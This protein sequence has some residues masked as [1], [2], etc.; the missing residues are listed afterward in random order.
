MSISSALQTGV[1]GL[2]ANSRA[3]GNISENIANANTVGYKRG[4]AQMVTTTSSGSSGSGVL[5]VSAVGQLDMETAGGLISTTSATDLAIGGNGFFVVSLN[6]NETAQSNYMLTRAGS[7][8]PD[9]NGDLKN[10]AGF[11]LAGYRY[12]LDGD[13]GSVD[14]STFAQMETVNLG[15]ISVSADGTSEMSTFGNLP[16]QDTG[17][18][19]P[20]APFA[21]SSEVFTSL[22]ASQRIGFSWQP[23][24][25]TNT[26]ELSL[27]DQNG[28]PLGSVTMDFNDSG[29][30][31]G[32]PLS[33]SGVTSTAVAPAAFSFDAATGT[34]SV[35]LN[36]GVTP[37]VV[38]IELGAP[39]TF[40]G[41]TQFA[42]D[43]SLSF[44]RNGT[45]VGQ[46]V[47]T[48]I[49]QEGTLFGVF[50][51]GL[52]T[53]IFD[54]PVA[55]VANPNGLVERKGNAYS[56][57]GESGAFFAHRANTSNVGAVNA[58]AL[59]GSNVDIAQ[60]MTDLIKAQRAFST[61]A[62]I[63]TTVDD[64]MDETTRLKR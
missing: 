37:Q 35:T 33:Y 39:G 11:F 10:S 53:A 41:V 5:S 13:L 4:F 6:P 24:A 32:S 44:E 1:S 47:R 57:S 20:G 31:A 43:F 50:D 46:L 15:N 23:T 21:S 42:G 12:N 2:Q 45:S 51:N 61:N 7:F 56:L 54:I 27:S 36:N 29:P 40:T 60:E 62:R 16:S 55:T 49:N 64:M 9:E 8:L 25:S 17:A 58:Q 52:R 30:L 14:R 63:I 18:A 48:E 19:V 26:W 3:V 34:A 28:A 59:E 38:E 22:G